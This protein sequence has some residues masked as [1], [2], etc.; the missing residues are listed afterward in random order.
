MTPKKFIFSKS[1]KIG[2][3]PLEWGRLHQI[4]KDLKLATRHGPVLNHLQFGYDQAHILAD[5]SSCFSALG[6][7]SPLIRGDSIPCHVRWGLVNLW[8]LRCERHLPTRSVSGSKTDRFSNSF[9]YT[10][11]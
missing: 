3:W 6:E 11:P 5:T 8:T 9:P 7:P 2:F 4:R 1:V 10:L